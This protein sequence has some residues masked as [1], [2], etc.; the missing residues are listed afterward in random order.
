[1][2]APDT[3]RCGSRINLG[4]RATNLDGVAQAELGMR[5]ERA[6]V[7]DFT[8]P[9]GRSRMRAAVRTTRLEKRIAPASCCIGGTP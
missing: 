8:T 2:A 5:W 7:A 9:A 3:G 4:V 1:M 6:R